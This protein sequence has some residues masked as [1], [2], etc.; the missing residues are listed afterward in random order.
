[1]KSPGHISHLSLR[2]KGTLVDGSQSTRTVEKLLLF[3]L[4]TDQRSYDVLKYG[5]GTRDTSC[6]D[7]L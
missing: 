7:I 1:M 6:P 4:V 5:K 3:L 2:G